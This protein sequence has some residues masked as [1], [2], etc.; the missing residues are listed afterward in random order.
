MARV[1]VG[2]L[3]FV[4]LGSVPFWVMLLVNQSMKAPLI[5][6]TPSLASPTLEQAI[7]DWIVLKNPQATIKDFRG[8]PAVLLRVSKDAGLD[9]RLVLAICYKESELH[10]RAVSSKGAVGLCQIMPAT[11]ES[12]AKSAGLPPGDLKNPAYNVTI[13]VLYFKDQV[14]SFGMGRQAL[15]AYNRGPAKAAQWWSTDQYAGEVALAYLRIHEEIP[16]A[17]QKP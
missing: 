5:V 7:E 12:V 9:F 13:A 8:F 2:I 3:T 4:S 6:P 16:R 17:S 15:Q 1:W 14:A 10:P 11:A